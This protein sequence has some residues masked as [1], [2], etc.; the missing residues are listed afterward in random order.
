MIIDCRYGT[1]SM[2]AVPHGNCRPDGDHP[3]YSCGSRPCLTVYYEAPRPRL[4]AYESRPC[5]PAY[6]SRPCLPAYKA[7]LRLPAYEARSRLP[8]Y[9]A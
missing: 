4:A 2:I 8:V 1:R 5:L 7:R 9:D 3:H 6:G